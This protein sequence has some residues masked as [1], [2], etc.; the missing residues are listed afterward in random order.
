MTD[1]DDPFASPLDRTVIIP[2]PGGAKPAAARA[3][4]PRAAA[5]ASGPGAPRAAFAATAADNPLVAA[6]GPLLIAASQLRR[7]LHVD[8]PKALRMR[9]ADELRGF[10]AAAKAAG[11][12]PPTALAARYMLCT[13]LDEAAMSTPWADAG[14]WADASLLAEFHGETWGGEKVSDLIEKAKREPG[15]NAD[16]LALAY[17]VLAF[18]FEGKYRLKESGHLANLADGLYRVMMQQRPA[19]DRALSPAWRGREPDAAERAMKAVPLWAVCVAGAAV[20]VLAYVI[21]SGLLFNASRPAVLAADAIGGSAGA[22]LDYAPAPETA[23]G[24]DVAA[25]LS[26]FDGNTIDFLQDE[27][28]VSVTLRGESE[29]GVLFRTRSD[30]VGPAYDETLAAVANVLTQLSGSIVVTGHT[31]GTGSD[32]VND[33]LSARRADAVAAR[34]VRLGVEEDRLRA[35]GRGSREPLADEE[36]TAADRARNRRVE[37]RFRAPAPEDE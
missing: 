29:G 23:P 17:Y 13:M 21:F 3:A 18:G 4:P 34:L 16:F 27:R 20:L 6:S 37:I 26:P 24:L 35:V 25:A 11:V 2:S 1:K 22:S 33:A 9:I 32:R 5:A 19:P 28:V 14:G 36:R 7:T 31:D 30:D 8:D 10:D 15:Q 12:A